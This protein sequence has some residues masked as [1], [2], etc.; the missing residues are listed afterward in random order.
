METIK[1]KFRVLGP[2]EVKCIEAL[3][4][5]YL[6]VKTKQLISLF[7]CLYTEHYWIKLKEMQHG[8]GLDTF[9]I[10]AMKIDLWLLTL[11]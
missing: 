7:K 2:E 6:T 5:Q 8:E 11:W 4:Q 3:L 1:N 10:K 9:Q